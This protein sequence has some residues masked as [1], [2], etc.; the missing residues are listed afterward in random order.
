MLVAVCAALGS[1]R[2]LG[3]ATF[4]FRVFKTFSPFPCLCNPSLCLSSQ[5]NM[6]NY[7]LLS[8]N[9]L[10]AQVMKLQHDYQDLS[11]QSGQLENLMQQQIDQKD[12]IILQ[13]DII[14][15]SL[16]QQLNSMQNMQEKVI[17]L[18]TEN[19]LLESTIRMLQSKLSIQTDLY[20][21]S[22]EKI[23]FLENEIELLQQTISHTDKI[24]QDWSE[25]E[26]QLSNIITTL[27]NKIQ[28]LHSEK[29][30]QLEKLNTAKT[31]ESVELE[32]KY[33]EIVNRLNISESNNQ[34][35][36]TKL[37]KLS[38]KYNKLVKIANF[39]RLKQHGL[40]KAY[41]TP[42]LKPLA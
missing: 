6:P 31:K 19:D 10:I 39:I 14:I 30:T 23:A 2:A 28:I 18:E 34:Q 4:S 1:A 15:N 5:A 20:E 32:S 33:Y 37:T 29:S 40:A 7:T 13:K 8:K 35:L 17:S 41:T 3:P 25:K 12:S 21:E 26:Q 9:Q 11:S 38:K 42:A 22:V 24:Q 16:S 36:C 27:Q